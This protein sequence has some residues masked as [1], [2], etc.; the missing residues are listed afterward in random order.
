MEQK[1]IFLDID[2]TILAPGEG[3]HQT[4]RDGIQKARSRGHQVF[5]ST[6][7]PYVG[8]PEELKGIEMDGYICSAGSDI[9]VHGQNIYRRY[10][11]EQ[12]IRKACSLLDELK[13]FYVLEGFSENF[14]CTHGMHVLMEEEIKW[15]DNPEIARWK[16]FFRTMG[17]AKRYTE[18]DPEQSP[19]PKVTFLVWDRERMELVQ[20]ELSQDFYVAFFQT[21][22][23]NFY[24]GEL[25]CSE[26]NKGTA[27]RRTA[28]Y[29]KVDFANTIAFGDSM[30]DYQ[31]IE[32]AAC[33]VV[34]GNG[35]EKLKAI[36][37]RVCESVEEDGVIRELERMGIL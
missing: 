8:L 37:D 16:K 19:I 27:I 13:A 24:N 30:N 33:G 25:I 28:E 36:A 23:S 2:G 18:W 3:I 6:G 9:W 26:D 17:N 10:L 15:D 21:D 31:M 22:T 32:Q 5:I 35:D 11:Q 14:I 29:L 34:V 7:R 12:L 1:L 4:V 20:Q